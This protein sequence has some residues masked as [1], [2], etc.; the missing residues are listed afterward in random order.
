M[1]SN[2]LL[3]LNYHPDSDPIIICLVAVF[4]LI[5]ARIFSRN[6]PASDLFSMLRFSTSFLPLDAILKYLGNREKNGIK[7]HNTHE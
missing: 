2:E 7:S 1:I 3:I 5:S 4:L 6:V